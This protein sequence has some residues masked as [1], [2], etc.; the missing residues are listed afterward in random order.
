[1]VSN[2]QD[3]LATSLD[4]QAWIMLLVPDGGSDQE[5]LRWAEQTLL[6]IEAATAVG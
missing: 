6:E 5:V 2:L 3:R 4:D 1:L